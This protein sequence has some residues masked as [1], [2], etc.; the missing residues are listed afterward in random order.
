MQSSQQRSAREQYLHRLGIVQYVSKELHDIRSSEADQALDAPIDAPNT[1][2]A[3]DVLSELTSTDIPVVKSPKVKGDQSVEK[4]VITLNFALWQPTDHLLICSAVDGQL[5]DP[6][7]ITLLTNIVAAME[8]RS[9]SLPAFEAINWP[10]HSNMQGDEEEIR[11]Y[12]STLINARVNTKSINTLLLMGGSPENWLLS[13]E[14]RQQIEDGVLT[15]ADNLSVL[16]V[17][18]LEEMLDNPSHKR[19]TWRIISR[20]FKLSI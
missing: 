20:H 11:E 16:V 3:T 4:S 9:I 12:F 5:P 18:S 17:P 13:A 8:G 15:L 1:S 14:Q 10:P 2:G 7:Q 19:V 6:Q